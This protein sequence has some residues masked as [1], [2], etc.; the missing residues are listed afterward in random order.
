MKL[1]VRMLCIGVGATVGFVLGG[2]DWLS[3]CFTEQVLITRLE[4]SGIWDH[5]S[6]QIALI[7]VSCLHLHL[8]RFTHIHIRNVNLTM[9]LC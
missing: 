4:P 9:R 7:Y 2:I 6:R 3:S 1:C 8:S 5:C